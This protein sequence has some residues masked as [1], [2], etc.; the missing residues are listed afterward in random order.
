[1][2]FVILGVF[3]SGMVFSSFGFAQEDSQ[4]P[5][6]IKTAVGFWVID[7]ISDDVF[8]AAIQYFVENE[9]IKVPQ[10]TEDEGLRILSCGVVEN[11]AG[12]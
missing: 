9:M 12:S 4:I 5:G 3:V 7:Q 8:L 6:W 2:L 1:M 11:F 10:K